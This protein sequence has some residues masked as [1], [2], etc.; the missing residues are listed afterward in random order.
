VY[1]GLRLFEIGVCGP[2][3]KVGV[4]GYV[5]S[6]EVYVRP[7]WPR[8]VCVCLCVCDHMSNR[9]VRR[10]KWPKE[11]YEVYGSSGQ[12]HIYMSKE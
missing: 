12:I 4:C 3:D 11:V 2:Y 5:R 6:G 9:V 7:R 8:G 1:A 10:T